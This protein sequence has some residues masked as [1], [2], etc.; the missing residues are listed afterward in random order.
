MGI[1]RRAKQADRTICRAC[2]QR[3]PQVAIRLVNG[4]PQ[5]ECYACR[6][7]REQ[8]RRTQA[9]AKQA[10]YKTTKTLLIANHTALTTLAYGIYPLLDKKERKQVGYIAIKRGEFYVSAYGENWL[11]RVSMFGVATFTSEL[12][13]VIDAVPLSL[14]SPEG[15]PVAL[16]DIGRGMALEDVAD[17]IAVFNAKVADYAYKRLGKQLAESKATA[18][19]AIRKAFNKPTS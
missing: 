9:S 8:L 16:E 1:R 15:A 6:N 5:G 18:K 13:L 10:L 3:E 12:G 7:D 4:K 11:F 17:R 2:K 14:Q 19:A